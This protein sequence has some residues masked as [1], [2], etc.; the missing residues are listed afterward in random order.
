VHKAEVQ[1]DLTRRLGRLADTTFDLAGAAMLSSPLPPQLPLPVDTSASR[2]DQVSVVSYEPENVE[3]STQSAIAGVLILS[4]QQFPG[5]ETTV[6]GEAEPILTVDNALRGVYLPAGSHSVV[7]AY[8]PLSFQ[9]GAGVS[10]AG[11]LALILLCLK[12]RRAV[13]EKGRL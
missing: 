8:K 9:T 2:G 12:R 4:D 5:W 1:T 11:I 6:D 10:I 7:F 3:I 13:H